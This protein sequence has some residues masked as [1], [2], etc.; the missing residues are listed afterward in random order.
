VPEERIDAALRRALCLVLPSRREGYGLVVIEAAARGT[1]SVVIA[2]KDNAAVELVE[3]GTNG[4]VAD[5]SQPSVLADAI[6]RVHDAGPP[7]RRST[8]AW[9][10]ENVHRLSLRSS[11]EILV[12]MHEDE[13]AGMRAVPRQE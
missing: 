8:L 3:E 6:E 7:L 10:G 5:A 1:P 12:A 4:E 2:G 9:F 11:L 13:G